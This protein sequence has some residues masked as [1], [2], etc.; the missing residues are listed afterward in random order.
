M[1]ANVFSGQLS[2]SLLQCRTRSDRKASLLECLAQV[3]AH[4]EAVVDDK[5][6]RFHN[7]LPSFRSL[8]KAIRVGATSSIESTR[9]AAPRRIASQGMPKTTELAS[10]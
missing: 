2:A 5:G 7:I 9:W 1:I 6:A 8:V 3:H 4:G 10:F